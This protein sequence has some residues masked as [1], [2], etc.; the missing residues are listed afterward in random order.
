MVINNSIMY[1]S[2]LYIETAIAGTLGI[3]FH[4]FVIKIPGLRTRAK[5][6]N[7]KFSFKAYLLDDY[8]GIIAS[9]LTLG[10]AILALDE[11]IG[12]RPSLLK[13]IKYFYFFVG[14]TGSSI[15]LAILSKTSK[16][17]NAIVDL[18]TDIADKK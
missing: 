9:F 11:L 6:A 8:P 15:L 2:E 10:I 7:E 17:I 13:F 3:L 12:Y 4:I 16:A 5:V 18:K 14:Y 1:K